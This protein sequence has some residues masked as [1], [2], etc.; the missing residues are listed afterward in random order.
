MSRSTTAP[1]TI[2]VVRRATLRSVHRNGMGGSGMYG[3]YNGALGI[4]ERILT[5]LSRD[6]GAGDYA[7]SLEHEHGTVRTRSR[8]SPGKFPRFDE[9]V[10]GRRVVDFG[11]GFGFRA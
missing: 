4:T 2:R 1:A 3:W 10:A 6:P 5:L 7:A 9:L 11:C 8:P